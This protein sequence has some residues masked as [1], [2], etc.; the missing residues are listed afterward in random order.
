MGLS[1]QV[2]VI[3][4]DHVRGT[5][6]DL[7]GR[8][9][10][11]VGDVAAWAVHPGGPKILDV[12]GERLGLDDDHLFASRQVLATIGNASSATVLVILE[13]VLAT[14]SLQPGD[15]VVLMAFGPGLTLYSAL[16]R[17]CQ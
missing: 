9:G 10:L 3:L 5:V 14:R 6:E 13:R 8:H 4:A 11:H 15:P 17:L 16:L 1:P 7:L 2:P 12:V